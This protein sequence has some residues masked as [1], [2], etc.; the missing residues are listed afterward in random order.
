MLLFYGQNKK[1]SHMAALPLLAVAK[2]HKVSAV[3]TFAILR[4]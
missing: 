1:V 3:E 2:P 4:N